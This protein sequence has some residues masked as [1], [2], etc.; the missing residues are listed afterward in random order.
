MMS[1]THPEL[2]RHKTP[3]R[4]GIGT[5]GILLLLV[6]LL[7]AVVVGLGLAAWL[8]GG[9]L[10]L[11]ARS[12]GQSQNQTQEPQFAYV[13]FGPTLVNLA[14]GRLTRYLKVGIALQVKKESA[15]TVK[16]VVNGERQALFRNWLIIHLSDLT[17]EDVKGSS[18]VNRLRSEI[19]EGFNRLL[20]KYCEARVEDVLF[21]EFSIQ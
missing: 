11:V 9:E 3:E 6:T 18:S 5:T 15:E 12:E 21:E 10:P 13:T 7:I 14:E 1:K 20:S 19:L 2:R 8:T 4:R 16:K 17:L